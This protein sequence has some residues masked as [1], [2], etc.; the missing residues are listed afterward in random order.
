VWLHLTLHNFLGT[1]EI[2]TIAAVMIV[3][4]AFVDAPRNE[5][6][7]AAEKTYL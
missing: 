5:Y 2:A 3:V 4:E 7:T 6:A 1:N